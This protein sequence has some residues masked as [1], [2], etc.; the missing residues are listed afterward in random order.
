[1]FACN[2]TPNRP[3]SNQPVSM[4]AVTLSAQS[5]LKQANNTNSK[6]Q[7]DKL[8]LL[9]V[10]AH[11]NDNQTEAAEEILQRLSQNLSASPTI[12]AQYRY[13]SAKVLL[14]RK[15][16]GE[17]LRQLKYTSQWQL[18]TWQWR[19]YH[20]TRAWLY[21]QLQQPLM[22]IAEL[23]LLSKFVDSQEA[24]QVNDNIWRLLRPIPQDQLA[25][26]AQNAIEPL[27]A[28]WLQLAYI[29]KHYGADP[30]QLI[31]YL[32]RWQRQHKSHPAALK[33]PSDLEKALNT[34]PYTPKKIA[35]LLPLSGDK[36]EIANPVRVGIL[37]RYLKEP[38]GNVQLEFYDTATDP[39]AAY[40]KALTEGAEFVIGPLLPGNLNKLKQYQAQN[41]SPVPQLYLNQVE[42]FT[43]SE[44]QFYFS[45]SPQQEAVDAAMHMFRSNIKTPLI[46]ASNNNIGHRMAAAFNE[47]WQRLTEQP[48]EVHFYDSGDKMKVT[49]QK[50]MGVA[51]SKARIAKMK[52]AVGRKLKADFRSRRDIDAIYMIASARDLPLLKPF[53]DVNFSVFTKPV[54][55]YTTSRSRPNG[56]IRRSKTEY[57][58]VTIS[59]A[60]WLMQNT[61]DNRI[62]DKLW[63]TWNN[64]QQ[65]L[66]AMG[67]DALELVG[68]LAQMRAFPGFHYKGDSGLL[69]VNEQGVIDR[70]LQWGKYRRGYLLPL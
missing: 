58:G 9:A 34:Q 15:Q 4:E 66:Y 12:Q 36:G 25:E 14:K 1:M 11:L 13:L 40:Q 69:S 51:D 70:Q 50:A 64:G 53:I 44:N 20:Q 29:A 56:D 6:Q 39:I 30:N 65:R 47:E 41:P 3:I 38:E 5:Y 24:N 22:Q 60:P 42:Q 27:N 55:L 52:A 19:N 63:P 62:V 16:Y 57:D 10:K 37:S 59:E 54:P 48:A 7:K 26:L 45:L 33:L 67:V 43:P 68:K 61:P 17:A 18:P 49:V 8:L 35:V 23:S 21:E 32:G 2:S 46:F 28:G 31:S